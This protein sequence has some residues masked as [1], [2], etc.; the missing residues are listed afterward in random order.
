MYGGHPDGSASAAGPSSMSVYINLRDASSG[1]PHPSL[2]LWS[3]ACW[4][5]RDAFRSRER[6]KLN[7]CFMTKQASD[8][9]VDSGSLF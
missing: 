6:E 8:S 7:P 2:C 1:P 5:E 3:D 4:S 9:R